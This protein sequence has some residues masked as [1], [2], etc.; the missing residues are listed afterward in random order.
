MKSILVF[1]ISVT[2][3]GTIQAQLRLPN[4]VV[5]HPSLAGRRVGLTDIEIRY[6]SPG[7]KGREGKIWGTDIAPFGFQVLGFGSNMPSPWRAGANECTTFSFSTDFII[8]GKKLAAGKYA[9]FI[10]LGPDTATLIFNSNTK[11]WGSYFYNKDLDVLHVST[12]IQ[13]DRPQSKEWLEYTFNNQTENKVEVALEWEKWRIPFTVEVDLIYTTLSYIRTQLTTDLGFNPPSLEQGA[14]WCLQNNV[15]YE[16]AYEWITRATDPNLGAVQSFRA[17]STKAGLLEKLN[18]KEEADKVMATALES[19]TA[20]EL[21]QYGRQLL[22]QQK[23]TEAMAVF[24]KNYK[25]YKGA[26][27]TNVGMMRGY[28]AMGNYKKA[29]EHAKLALPQAP[30]DQN[31]KVI[32]AAIKTL[33]ENKPI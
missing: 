28:S 32:E 26:W 21:H 17:L 20:I 19:G 9:F 27:P 25:K 5:N 14:T 3:F 12:S 15:N 10:A 33:S 6:N 13:K 4:S 23:N 18:R 29:L 31:K 2:F 8:N 7:V 11:S 24:E 30:D 22:A 1:M 16:Q